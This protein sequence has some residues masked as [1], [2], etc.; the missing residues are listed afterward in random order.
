MRHI[1][2]T[3][4]LI[5]PFVVAP[6]VSARNPA[7]NEGLL[8][9][10]FAPGPLIEGHKHL[11]Q[12]DCLKCHSPGEG[13]TDKNCLDCH[14]SVQRERQSRRGFHGQV[15]ERC[16]TCHPDHRG[17]DFDG[18][19]IDENSF[20]HETTGFALEGRHAVI[21]CVKCHPAADAPIAPKGGRHG[22]NSASCRSCHAKDDP[23]HYTGKRAK[24]ECGECHSHQSWTR[25]VRFDHE[26]ESGFRLDPTHARLACKTC[27]A[28]RGAKTARYDFP[29]VKP[30]KCVAC[31]RDVVAM[32]RHPGLYDHDRSGFPLRGRHTEIGCARCH[33]ADRPLGSRLPTRD[34]A[35]C[36]AKDS[37]HAFTG[38]WATTS[39][40][41]CHE[42]RAWK[43]G[44]RFDHQ[45]ASG[46]KLVGKHAEIAC[47]RCHAPTVPDESRYR[48]ANLKTKSCAT[49]H[50]DPHAGVLT[51]NARSRGCASCHTPGTWRVTAYDHKNLRISLTGGHSR[52]ACAKCHRREGRPVY[53]F[54]DNGHG[55]CVNCHRDPHEGRMP[56]SCT[57]CHTDTTW[58]TQR[59]FH[60]N[61]SLSGAHRQL[62]CEQ[63]HVNGRALAG[64]SENCAGCHQDD[65]PHGGTTASVGSCATC[66]GQTLWEAPRFHHSSTRFPLRGAHRLLSCTECHA[67]GRFGGTPSD[68]RDCHAADA[69]AVRSPDHRL[70]A[71]DRCELCHN[72]FSF[73]M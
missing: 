15:E 20:K 63:C 10:L 19:R 11:E 16:I 24:I 65:D 34:C 7:A 69:A 48:F 31:H 55:Q 72:Q 73:S 26:R 21:A 1:L 66:H 71:F 46:F 23:H 3:A 60:R 64:Q 67:G 62:A 37:K 54:V 39:C 68:C 53:R 49:C 4:L 35:A 18:T 50:K 22:G 30:D 52:I 36:H 45:Q 14:P 12:G 17:R 51:D 8:N 43:R 56:Q 40:G 47:A 33:P 6:V 25:D 2:N 59:D 41:T 28:P 5:I 38:K 27:H 57:V 44:V 9:Q 42:T 61:F 58:K 13:V 70:P 29:G 32:S